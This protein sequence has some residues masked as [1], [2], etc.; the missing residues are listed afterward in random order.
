[1]PVL[2]A[3]VEVLVSKSESNGS[4]VYTDK[5]ELLDTGNGD[6]DITKGDGVYTRYFSAAA[7]GPGVYTFEVT[8]SDNGNTAYSEQDELHVKPG[9][10]EKSLSPFQRI[11]PPITMEIT[12]EDILEAAQTTV[13]C[14][15]DLK[16]DTIID[17]KVHLSFTA[18]DMNGQMVTR[19]EIKYAHTVQ[20]I[21]NHFEQNAIP[22]EVGS[23]YLLPPGSETTFTLNFSQDK[24]LLDKP[25]Y[26]AIKAYGNEHNLS[27]GTL[28]NWV[29]VYVSSPPPPPTVPPTHASNDQSSWP[30]ATAGGADHANP[31]V[32]KH[33]A[34]GL[35]LILPVAIG[36]LL[37]V[38]LL[39]LY[40]YFC[41]VRRKK[42]DTH[43][44]SPSHKN[45]KLNSTI[46]IVPSSPVHNVPSPAYTVH[47]APDPH[48][49]GVPINN[50]AYEEETK[51]RFS[52]VHQ[53]EQQLIEEL[54]Q[55]QQHM[56][57]QP[58]NNYATSGLSV[59]STGGTLQRNGH[60]LSPYNS[61]SAS[62]L[63]HEHERRHSPMQDEQMHQERQEAYLN[64]DQMSLNGNGM[65]H[66]SLNGHY[67][68]PPPV[69]PLPAFTPNGYPIN[70][71]IYGVHH[72]VQQQ[73]YQS[74]QRNEQLVPFNQSL[75]GSMSS[76]NSGDKKRRNVTMV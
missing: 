56:Q 71:N 26:F 57:Q 50:Y 74:M 47:D 64:G 1:M 30:F 69:P 49:V 7:G 60:T 40:C 62:Q 76:V 61:W 51:K 20:D 12:S 19:Y 33:V 36:F 16:V 66:V 35:E 63:L 21:V 41:V 46:T 18:P 58:N 25:L 37:L 15:G 34:F 11:L 72:P 23:P 29:R 10:H 38:V 17:M 67:A 54:K 22:W 45:D 44:K 24:T 53:Q 43:K 59:I 2:H 55:Q 28:S 75:Q 8:V 31:S 4:I 3:K 48:T 65:D 73:I 14:I 68:H 70:Y 32:A 6:P 52:L 27:S 5:F 42:H 39:V 13:G 9:S